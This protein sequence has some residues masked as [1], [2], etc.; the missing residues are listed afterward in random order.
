MSEYPTTDAPF[1]HSHPEHQEKLA[2]EQRASCF[3]TAQ[4]Q[5]RPF[6]ISLLDTL[7]ANYRA[8]SGNIAEAQQDLNT[9]AKVID[10]LTAHPEFEEF[11]F[12]LKHIEA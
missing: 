11:I 3:G 4:A 8:L 12:V 10:I 2:Q 5:P 7:K 1:N 6:G 9:R